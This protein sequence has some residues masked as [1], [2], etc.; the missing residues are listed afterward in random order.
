MGGG[1]GTY[2]GFTPQGIIAAGCAQNPNY[3]KTIADSI[4]KE[5]EERKLDPPTTTT[6]VIASGKAQVS[7]T[8]RPSEVTPANGQGGAGVRK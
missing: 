2:F 5:V 8:A 7:P 4:A 6:E 1:G 3:G